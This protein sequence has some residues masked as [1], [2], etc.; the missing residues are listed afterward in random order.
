MRYVR[1]CIIDTLFSYI[2]SKFNSLAP[3]SNKSVCPLLVPVLILFSQPR[4]HLFNNLVITPKTFPTD[5]VSEG[6]KEME[7]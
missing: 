1:G 6:S 3:A 5:G 7:I 2:I 4:L